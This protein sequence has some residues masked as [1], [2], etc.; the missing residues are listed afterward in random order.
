MSQNDTSRQDG[1]GP[2]SERAPYTTHREPRSQGGS[3]YLR[4]RDCGAECMAG[5]WQWLSHRDGCRHDVEWLVEDGHDGVALQQTGS[6]TE[7]VSTQDPVDLEA[8]R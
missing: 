2:D 8:W 1:N 5:E 7:W 4:C 3:T 6:T